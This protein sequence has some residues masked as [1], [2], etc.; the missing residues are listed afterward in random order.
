MAKQKDEASV[1]TI[2]IED[3]L[4]VDKKTKLRSVLKVP[5]SESKTNKALRVFNKEGEQKLYASVRLGDLK[6]TEEGYECDVTGKENDLVGNRFELT[7]V[8]TKIIV[9]AGK[10]AV[11]KADASIVEIPKAANS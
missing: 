9:L 8:G 10:I 4:T 11:K 6:N 2:F 7:E 5:F 1:V 3:V